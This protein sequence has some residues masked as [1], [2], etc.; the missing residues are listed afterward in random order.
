MNA[1]NLTQLNPAGLPLDGSKKA[2]SPEKIKDAA[3]QFEALLIGQILR[4]AREGSEVQGDAATEF[5]EQNMATC[6]ARSG[7]LG[8]A[9]MIAKSLEKSS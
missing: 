6:L 9:G 7:G 3:E 5:A 1:L 8:L 4:S 2:D